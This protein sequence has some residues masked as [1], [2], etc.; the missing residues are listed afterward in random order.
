M[1]NLLDLME[2]WYAWKLSKKDFFAMLATFVI[3][4][5]FDTEIGL[6]RGLGPSII[7]LLRDLASSLEAKPISNAVEVIRRR[8]GHPPEQ[9]LDLHQRIAQLRY[10]GT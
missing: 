6:L 8:G 2:F 3:T 7:V 1:L 5:V 10:S 9:Q 4:L